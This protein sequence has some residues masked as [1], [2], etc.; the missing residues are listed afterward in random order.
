MRVMSASLVTDCTPAQNL[1]CG[2]QISQ[3]R[4]GCGMLLMGG[5][6]IK[7]TKLGILCEEQEHQPWELY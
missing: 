7:V 1:C 4:E 3:L 6:L 2:A 5:E